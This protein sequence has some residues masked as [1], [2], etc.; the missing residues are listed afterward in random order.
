MSENDVRVAGDGVPP[1]RPG[2]EPG[3]SHVRSVVDKPA[4]GE[5]FLRVLRFPLPLILLI[6]SIIQG[7]YNKPMNGW[8]NTGLGSTP[9]P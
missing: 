4:P 2:F 6:A 8:S 3:S 9:A 7:G 1:R 5:G